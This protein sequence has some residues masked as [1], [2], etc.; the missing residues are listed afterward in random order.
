MAASRGAP[1]QGMIC[2]RL[3]FRGRGKSV[4]SL[5][6]A[7]RNRERACVARK[8]AMMIVG[9]RTEALSRRYDFVTERDLRAAAAKLNAASLVTKSVTVG[10][11][12]AS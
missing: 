4:K 3:F 10:T 5:A 7:W 6:R 11:N 8:V 1:R 2:P 12:A 9:Q